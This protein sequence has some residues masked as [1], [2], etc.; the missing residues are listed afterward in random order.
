MFRV[1]V[2]YV[3]WNHLLSHSDRKRYEA[4]KGNAGNDDKGD[5]DDNR[6]VKPGRPFEPRPLQ[7]HTALSHHRCK[8]NEVLVIHGNDLWY[9][10]PHTRSTHKT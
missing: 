9:I 8:Q 3:I 6:I 10:G 4:E 7:D 1:T 5:K 2:R